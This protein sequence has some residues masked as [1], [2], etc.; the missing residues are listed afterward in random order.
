MTGPNARYTELRATKGKR[1][2]ELK[3]VRFFLFAEARMGTTEW[4]NGAGVPENMRWFRRLVRTSLTDLLAVRPAGF[5]RELA[6]IAGG[7]E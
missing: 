6:T 5:S 1:R 4:L 3:L 7:D 2:R